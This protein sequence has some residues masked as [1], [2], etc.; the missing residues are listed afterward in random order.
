M[1]QPSERPRDDRSTTPYAGGA[2]A[3]PDTVQASGRGTEPEQERRATPRGTPP[4]KGRGAL[5]MGW[6]VALIAFLLVLVLMFG[7]L[8]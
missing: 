7:A 5:S 2:D 1:K 4:A 6:I 8:R 3:V